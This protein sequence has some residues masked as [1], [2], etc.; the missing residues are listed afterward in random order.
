MKLWVD[1][2]F[3]KVS[4]NINTF[5]TY[6]NTISLIVAGKLS[7]TGGRATGIIV[8]MTNWLFYGN[9][10]KFRKISA[11]LKEMKRSN[12]SIILKFAVYGLNAMIF[13]T[14]IVYCRPNTV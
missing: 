13:Y 11:Y 9:A 7:V 3:A 14:F 4:K 10:G 12:H 1:K 6:C 5:S 2:I 8:I